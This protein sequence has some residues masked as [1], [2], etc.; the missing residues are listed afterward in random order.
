MS[1]AFRGFLLYAIDD[2]FENG[3]EDQAL[4]AVED[5]LELAL[6]CQLQHRV[7][8]LQ[9]LGIYLRESAS[10]RKEEQ[11]GAYAFKN[12]VTTSAAADRLAMVL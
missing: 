4:A 12:W 11:G 9:Q 6:G 7:L 10:R 5:D 1:D 8:P 2:L 3:P